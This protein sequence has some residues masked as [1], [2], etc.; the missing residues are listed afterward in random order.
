MAGISPET[1]LYKKSRALFIL[2]LAA[3][4]YGV[5]AQAPVTSLEKRTDVVAHKAVRLLNEHKADSVYAMA[6]EAFRSQIS[7]A[8]WQQ[9][10]QKQL[11]NILPIKSLTYL[12]SES[13]INKYKLTAGVTLTLN[14]SLEGFDKIGNF[15]FTPYREEIKASAMTE[16]EERVN[17]VAM[18]VFNYLNARQPDSAYVFAGEKFRAFMSADTWRNFNAKQLSPMLPLPKPVFVGSKNGVNKYKVGELQFLLGLDKTG[19]FETL[20]L[21]PYHDEAVKTEKAATDNPLYSKLDSLINKWLS[22]YIQ[23]KGNV[24]ISAAVY[25]KG[26]DHYYNY[27][28]TAKGDHKLPNAHTLYEIGSVTKTFTATLL[29]KAV[30]DGLVKL[31]DPIT[32]FLP[33]SVAG[34]ADLKPIT[35]KTIANHTSGL[36]R[37]PDNINITVTDLSQ[38][39]EHYDQAHLFAFLKKFKATRAPGVSY[40]YSNLAMGLLGVI[41]ERIYHKPYAELLKLYVTQP[42]Q[43]NETKIRLTTIEAKCLAQGYDAPGNKAAPWKHITTQA[44]GA[45]VSSTSDML[46]Y[47]KQQLAQFNNPLSKAISLTHQT[48]LDDGINKVALGWHYLYAD[49]DPVIQ[50][51]GATG[52]YRSLICAN[53]RKNIVLVILTNNATNGDALGLELMPFLEKLSSK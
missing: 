41:L 26:A 22:A 46:R 29:A 21:Q 35:L 37:M 13:G 52:G 4:S 50:H 30:T 25:Y 11:I 23:T 19:F 24:G 51:G 5:K 36:P 43:L 6:G 16:S 17:V 10:Y 31:D 14:I 8:V 49:A 42:L 2:F 33:D 45:I 3:I 44:A 40:E 15:S 20:L 39:Y 27:G 1:M 53:L 38:P 28:E 18:K 34:N 47:G 12:G 48:T 9:V 7:P 32:K